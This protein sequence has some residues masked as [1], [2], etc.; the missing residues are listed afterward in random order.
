MAS[1]K[2]VEFFRKLTQERD[3]T[4]HNVHNLREQFANLPDKNASQWIEKALERPR[5]AGDTEDESQYVSP[6]F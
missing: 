1:A 6:P 3:F 5:L 4:G 2:Q